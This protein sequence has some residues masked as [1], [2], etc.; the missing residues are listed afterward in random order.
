MIIDSLIFVLVE[1]RLMISTII[2]LHVSLRFL[3]VLLV[4]VLP[5]ICCSRATFS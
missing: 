2:N 4:T 1:T 5:A 3:E